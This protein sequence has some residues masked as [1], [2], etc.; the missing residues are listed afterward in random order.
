LKGAWPGLLKHSTNDAIE[1]NKAYIDLLAE[2][3]MSRVSNIKRDPNKVKNLLKSLARNIATQ[4]ETTSLEKDIKIRKNDTL[5][6]PSLI[7][8]LDSLQRLMIYVEQAAFG[9]HIRSANSLRVSPKRHLCDVSLAAAALGLTKESLLND[10]NYC[11]F[12]FESL[13]FHELK[14]YAQASDAEVFHY[15]DSTNLEIDS[16]VQKRNGDWAAFEVKLGSGQIEEAAKNLLH[17]NSIVDT[18]KISLPKSLNIITGTGMSHRRN[19]GV[20]VISIASLGK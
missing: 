8:Y 1:I 5:S 16:I 14:I 2:V 13:V 15:R 19:D 10:L 12:L 3:D 18:S 11:G 20:N 4:V 6:R 9:I 17:L 7:D